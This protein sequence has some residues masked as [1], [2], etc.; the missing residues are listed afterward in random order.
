M[1]QTRMES[2]V[3][4]TR[5]ED[6]GQQVAP[7][8]RGPARLAA[9]TRAPGTVRVNRTVLTVLGLL[10]VAAGAAGLATALGLFGRRLSDQ[11][12]LGPAVEDFV[13]ANRWFW[14]V[15][16][17]AAALLALLCLWWLLSQA[18]SNRVS[19]LRLAT[20]PQRGHTT[21]SAS[22]LTDAVTGEI[23]GY[24]GVTRAAAHL[25]GT[26][27]APRLSLTVAL[28]GRVGPGEIHRRITVE[29]IPHARQA[30]STDHL[31]TRLELQ[32]PR[33]QHR[34]VQ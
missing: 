5:S 1:S 4:G 21:L 10:L 2:T 27:T 33:T 19:Q 11:P 22:A 24:H 13:A 30:L 6:G 16:A 34:D 29:A 3:T 12:V 28:D 32:L 20:D 7:T 25:S 18:R 31:P 8:A 15:V 9:E 26:S 14:P 23:E 17:I